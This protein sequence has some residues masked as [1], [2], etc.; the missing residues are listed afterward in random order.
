MT[1]DSCRDSIIQPFTPTISKFLFVPDQAD[2]ANFPFK[3]PFE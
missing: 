1:V 2:A 3:M